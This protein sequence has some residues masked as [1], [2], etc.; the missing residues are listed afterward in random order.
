MRTIAKR[1]FTTIRVDDTD[2]LNVRADGVANI[3]GVFYAVNTDD[4]LKNG[5]IK[6]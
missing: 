2:V 1:K 3:D 5:V 4:Y 6:Y